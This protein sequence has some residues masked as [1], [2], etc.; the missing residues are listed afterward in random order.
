MLQIPKKILY[1]FSEDRFALA[2]SADSDEMPHDV[3]FHLGLN[4]LHTYPFLKGLTLKTPAKN[5][6]ENS[7]RFCRLLQIFTNII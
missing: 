1:F 3:A 5:S 7:V 6:S 4:C 2:N